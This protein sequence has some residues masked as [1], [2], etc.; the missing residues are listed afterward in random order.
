MQNH[1]DSQSGKCKLKTQWDTMLHP[2]D[3]QKLKGLTII[4]SLR[5]DMEQWKPFALLG[6]WTGTRTLNC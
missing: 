5:K 2:S 1:C 3:W 4:H 6:I